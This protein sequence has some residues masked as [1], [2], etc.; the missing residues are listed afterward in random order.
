MRVAV[1]GSKPYDQAFLSAANQALGEAGHDLHY[2]H[3]RLNRETWELAKGFEAVCVFVNDELTA[4]VLASLASHGLRFVAL[5][6]AG[7]NNVDLKMADQL[8]ISVVRVPAYS[9]ESVAEHAVGLMLTL[10]RKYHRAFQ[11]VRDGNFAL[12]GLL[13]FNFHG[14]TAGLIGLGKIGLATARILKGLG[15][16]VIGFDQVFS[17]AAKAIGIEPVSLETLYADSDVISLH[18]PLT[19]DTFHLI[20]E[21]SLAQMRRGV[22]LINTSRGGLIDTAAVIAALK[23]E[24]LGYLGL[25]VYEQEGDLFFEDLSDKVIADDAFERLLTFPN[26][27]ITG[28]Q[29][30]FTEEAL[31]SIAEV[32]LRNLVQLGQGE[33]CPNLL[34]SDYL[35]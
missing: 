16:R 13:G 6:C 9:P 25:D 29:G 26:V 20:N 15:M 28:H 21:Y 24:Q 17:E 19:R 33:A 8:G 23:S 3:V 1:F 5:R 22:M 18:C 32:T 11:R 10:S 2:F 35:A 34:G 27:L 31:G 12:Q 4:P 7:F 14:R 30:F